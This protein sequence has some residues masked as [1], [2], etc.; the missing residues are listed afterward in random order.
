MSFH[1]CLKGNTQS[2]QLRALQ[3]FARENGMKRAGQSGRI[4]RN[5]TQGC[6]RIE[7]LVAVEKF[8]RDLQIRV[9]SEA[10]SH[11]L[12]HSIGH[13]DGKRFWAYPRNAEVGSLPDR[14]AANSTSFELFIFRNCPH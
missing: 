2:E 1:R 3:K 4:A 11:Q 14:E 6:F 5:Q 7:R 12:V 8:T 13:S 10:H 9:Q